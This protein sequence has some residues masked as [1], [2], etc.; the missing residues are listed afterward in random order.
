M[1]SAMAALTVD[2]CFADTR[3]MLM[4]IIAN[5]HWHGAVITLYKLKIDME[6]VIRPY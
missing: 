2:Q 1:M 5:V 6:S 4:E 3:L